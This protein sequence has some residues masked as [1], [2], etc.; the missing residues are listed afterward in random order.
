VRRALAARN[1]QSDLDSMVKAH[2]DLT[3]NAE[4]VGMD[5]S[6]VSRDVN[7]G[8]SGGEKKRLE[9]LQMLS[10]KPKIIILD[11]V[12]SGLDVDGIKH[13]SQAIAELNDGTRGF[14]V[15]TH[16]PRILNHIKPDYVHVLVDGKIALS[17]NESLAHEIEEKGYSS[18]LKDKN[19]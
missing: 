13:I 11:E 2:E 3:R 6:F 7:V 16:Y 8:F 14:L 12:D 15:I 10:L 5:K 19:D 17:G 1:G 18:Y 4:K 9:V